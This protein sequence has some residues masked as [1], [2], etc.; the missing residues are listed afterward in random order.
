MQSSVRQASLPQLI[1][2]FEQLTREIDRRLGHL[3]A[4]QLNWRPNPEE[5]SLGQCLEHLIIANR[6]YFVPLEQLLAGQKPTTIWERLPVAPALFARLLIDA[7]EPAANRR[8][9]APKIFQPGQSAVERQILTTF[10][11][12]QQRMVELMRACE[13][14]D[15][16]NIIITSPIAAF[17]TYSLLDA[18][19]IIVVHAQ[20]HLAQ[21]VKLLSLPEFPPR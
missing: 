5:W 14:L 7:L 12:Q 13:R 10:A 16:A 21:T 4:I 18:F 3:S 1:P 9:Q 8:V 19:R 6:A 17:V 20:H 11:Q 2:L 15:A